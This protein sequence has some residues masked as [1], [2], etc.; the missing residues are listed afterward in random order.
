MG[1]GSP[2]SLKLQSLGSHCLCSFHEQKSNYILDLG[3]GD[4]NAGL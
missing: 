4:E 3:R 2:L 1:K